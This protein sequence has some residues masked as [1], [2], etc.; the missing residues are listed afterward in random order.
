MTHS[1]GAADQ[2]E[3]APLLSRAAPPR[4]GRVHV[5]Q[6]VQQLEIEV[7]VLQRARHD[8]PVADLRG[9]RVEAEHVV[10]RQ[11]ARVLL[12]QA[13]DD[14]SV[15]VFFDD[16]V[17]QAAGG[18][19][20]H[21][22]VAVP[23]LDGP[24]HRLAQLV[25]AFQAGLVRRVVSVQEDRHVGDDL[26]VHQA[27]VDEA[28]RVANA[29]AVAILS[30]P[31]AMRDVEVLANEGL[32]EVLAQLGFHRVGQSFGRLAAP[33]RRCDAE[34]RGS[35]GRMMGRVVDR[36]APIDA[37]RRHVVIEKRFVL[38]VA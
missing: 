36:L 14:L 38:V 20:R 23:R 10:P 25:A 27:P 2:R 35:L 26:V 33:C 24:S 17:A 18:D 19:E 15:Q 9:A 22:L 6:G 32:D 29:G 34:G 1:V 5:T 12:G 31:S 16:E 3:H 13:G 21:G 37:N 4:P 11:L 8:D 28:E 7:R 30:Q